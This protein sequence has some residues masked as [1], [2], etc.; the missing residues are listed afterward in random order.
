M[1]TLIWGDALHGCPQWPILVSLC[2]WPQGCSS[3]TSDFVL[4]ATGSWTQWTFK[5]SFKAIIRFACLCSLRTC[6]Y[7]HE[8]NAF[9]LLLIFLP[10]VLPDVVRTGAAF[11]PG[12]EKA[13]PP[14]S[15]AP[16]SELILPF[17][18]GDLHSHLPKVKVWVYNLV[19][20]SYPFGAKKS[21]PGWIIL[22][23]F[24]HFCYS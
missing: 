21:Q 19:E 8:V 16:V 22:Y 15:S 20:N 1:P 24:L 10:S 9:S 23:I 7:P 18:P 11:R 14:N 17:V 3:R 5:V 2:I 4:S 13:T 6:L 12:E